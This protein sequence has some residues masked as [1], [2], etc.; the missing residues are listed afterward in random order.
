MPVMSPGYSTARAMGDPI[1]AAPVTPE[2]LRVIKKLAP[3]K[4]G[5]RKL[6]ARYG[7]ALVCVRH[8]MDEQGLTRYTTVELLVDRAPVHKRA[9]A[10]GSASGRSASVQLKLD[11]ARQNSEMRANIL[12]LGGTWDATARV[13]AVPRRAVK[14]LGLMDLVIKDP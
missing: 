1:D 4:P 6:A 12:A 2:R 10:S 5:A 11:A 8:R 14:Q 3:D 9:A 13:W 7:A